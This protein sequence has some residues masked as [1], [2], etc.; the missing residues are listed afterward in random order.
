MSLFRIVYNR[1]N[2]FSRY[3]VWAVDCFF[4][5]IAT[6]LSYLFFNYLVGLDVVPGFIW[7][8]L[9]ASTIATLIWTWVFKTY[10]G[11]IRHATITDMHRIILA[12]LLKAL[13]LLLLSYFVSEYVGTFVYSIL[14][15][16]FVL[17]IFFLITLRVFLVSFYYYITNANNANRQN[18]LIYGTSDAAISLAGFLRKNKTYHMVGFITADENKKSYRLVG[19]RIYYVNNQDHFQ[20]IVSKNGVKSLLFVS[21]TDLHKDNPFVS[22]GLKN[23][24]SLRIAPMAVVSEDA[25]KM[26]LRN[27]QIED[28]LGRNEID[29][30]FT[31]IQ[32]DFKDKVVLVTG[33][34][35]SIGSELCRQLCRCDL[36]LLVLVDFSE[37]ATYQIDLEL[38][39]DHP[40]RKFVSIIADVRNAHRMEGILAAYKPDILFHAAA[41]KHVPLMEEYPCEAV[42]DNVGGTRTVADLAVKY[43][44]GK[45][46]MISTDKAVRPS[47]VMGA[48]KRLAEI[49]VQSLGEAIKEGKVRGKT[50]F[51]TTRFGNVLGSNGS[52]IPLFRKQIMEGGPVTVTD[53]EI[54]RYFMTIP[55]ACRLVL[56]AAHIGE[57]NDIYIFDMGEPVKIADL[58]TR[59]IELSGYRPGEDI[60]I[61]YTG[62]RPG[63]KLYEELLYKKENTIPTENAKIFCAET[64][65]Y[66]YDKI[67]ASFD[68]LLEMGKNESKSETVRK[69]K[70]ILSDFKSLNSEFAQFDNENN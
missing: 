50:T 63:E 29:I 41:Y 70:E 56:E 52:V 44:V 15:G 25:P 51:V 61:V 35:G 67:A 31:K 2:H 3:I 62:L 27:V 23:N 42:L 6:L 60:K 19:H 12:M 21:N 53:P 14:I 65:R 66:D 4:S 59:M 33:A 55:E 40:D 20:S 24:V 45:F 37:S 16:D 1:I 38:K 13:T 69:M 32:K 34:A 22:Y 43:G 9:L 18:V 64:V 58:A 28:L 46:V 57:G 10:D 54:I 68:E 30:D 39:K 11:I 49:Y 7:R 47:S 48:T 5:V 36:K 8:M 17:S 26:Q